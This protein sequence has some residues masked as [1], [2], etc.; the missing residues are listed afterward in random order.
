MTDGIFEDW[1]DLVLLVL[2]NSKSV[3]A[4]G[5]E[6]DAIGVVGTEVFCTVDHAKN[7]SLDNSCGVARVR[8]NVKIK[9]E[10]FSKIFVV[11]V[12]FVI[13][14]SRSRNAVELDSLLNVHWRGRR[15][16]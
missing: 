7:D 8:G 11:T 15:V 16:G 9:I 1:E 10:G 5:E 6:R 14:I 2:S 13:V 12:P 3:V 4:V